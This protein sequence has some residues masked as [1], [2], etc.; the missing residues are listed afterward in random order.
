[1][2]EPN[3]KYNSNNEHVIII[4][5]RLYNAEQEVK[6]LQRLLRIAYKRLLYER[7]LYGTVSWKQKIIDWMWGWFY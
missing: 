5:D 2:R 4:R 1:M 3:T 7:S 6:E